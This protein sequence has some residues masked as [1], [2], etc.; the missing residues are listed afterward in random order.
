MVKVELST[1]FH[2]DSNT[3]PKT[4]KLQKHE[5]LQLLVFLFGMM[6]VEEQFASCYCYIFTAQ[7]AQ[8]TRLTK[9]LYTKLA[10]ERHG[11]LPLGGPIKRR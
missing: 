9:H 6:Y 11:T 7:E 5:W 10:L 3:V 4:I 2:R 8:E 1:T